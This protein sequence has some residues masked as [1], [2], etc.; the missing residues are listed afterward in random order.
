MI[1][2]QVADGTKHAI[3]RAAGDTDITGLREG[4]EV[5]ISLGTTGHADL[6]TRPQMGFSIPR[7]P[8][9]TPAQSQRSIEIKSY[10]ESLSE[11]YRHC[12]N[13]ALNQLQNTGLDKAEIKD[14]ATSLFIQTTRHFSI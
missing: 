14:V 10:V 13:T 5:E 7:P 4:E 9:V 11:L 12:Y 3:Y 8:V 2:A 6:V 1:Y